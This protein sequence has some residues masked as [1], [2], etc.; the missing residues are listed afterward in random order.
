MQFYNLACRLL[1]VVHFYTTAFK[2]F[3]VDTRN[4]FLITAMKVSLSNVSMVTTIW[5]HTKHT[6]TNWKHWPLTY[7][8]SSTLLDAAIAACTAARCSSY[9][10]WSE[11]N[12]LMCSTSWSL[13]CSCDSRSSFSCS[14]NLACFLCVEFFNRKSALTF[15]IRWSCDC[16]WKGK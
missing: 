15:A 10:S 1:K 14:R 6:N 11:I 5:T 9:R 4:C 3:E 12:F 16:N 13:S 7:H 2:T 8:T